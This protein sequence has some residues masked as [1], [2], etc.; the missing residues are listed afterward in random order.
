MLTISRKV[1]NILI[2]E[3]V[4]DRDTYGR[5]PVVCALGKKRVYFLTIYS[6]IS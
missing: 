3:K 5:T 1:S 6:V 4:I 2:Q